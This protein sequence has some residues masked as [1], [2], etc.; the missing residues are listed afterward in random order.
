MI[1]P[2]KPNKAVPIPLQTGGAFKI[3]EKAQTPPTSP[4]ALSAKKSL[5]LEKKKVEVLPRMARL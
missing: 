3:F 5:A 2:E 4:A 1:E